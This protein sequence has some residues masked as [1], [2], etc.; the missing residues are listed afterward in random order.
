LK[1]SG[2]WEFVKNKKDGISQQLGPE[3]KGGVELSGGEWQKL[4]IARAHAKKAPILIL[5]EPTSNVDAKS[6]MEIF[7]KINN[8]LKENTL[9]F[10]SHRFST[11]KDAER[12]VVLD[13]GKI[14]EDGTHV[15]LIKK[16]GTYA[17]LYTLQADRYLRK[18]NE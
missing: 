10:I 3:Y 11:I 15:D 18:E 8:E 9:I 13:K 7:D 5:D 1:F 14:I 12:I 17:H 6:E 2:A 4:S 16:N